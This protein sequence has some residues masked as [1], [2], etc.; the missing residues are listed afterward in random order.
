MRGDICSV[1]GCKK[2]THCKGV[3]HTHYMAARRAAGHK[4]DPN[5]GRSRS[6]GT[7]NHHARGRPLGFA[8]AIYKDRIPFS[9]SE[10]PACAFIPGDQLTDIFYAHQPNEALAY[11]RTCPVRL[12]C[13][14]YSL[15]GEHG[16]WGGVVHANRVAWKREGMT[17]VEMIARQDAKR[18]P[19][20]QQKAPA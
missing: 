9:P 18:M 7:G 2:Q 12:E 20:G 5:T 1:V 3:C 15:E 13:L 16:T 17:P 14:V 19:G 6:N 8:E 11:C 4:K 10:T